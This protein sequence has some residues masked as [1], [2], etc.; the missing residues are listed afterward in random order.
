MRHEIILK[1][2]DGTKIKIYV[3]LV[4]DYNSCRIIH[5]VLKCEKGK[6]TYEDVVDENSWHYRALNAEKRQDYILEAHLLHVT[7]EEIN[8]AIRELMD[9]IYK[10]VEIK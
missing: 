3:R 9:I 5:A 2:L 8:E 1:R 6:R 7:K 4:T 10:Q